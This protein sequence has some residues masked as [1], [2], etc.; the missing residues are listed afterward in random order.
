MNDTE[1]EGLLAQLS[2]LQ[3]G[4]VSCSR[5]LRIAR[6]PELIAPLRRKALAFT[7][8]DI[9][10]SSNVISSVERVKVAV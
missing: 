6:Q 3:Q 4:Q 5:S 10:L 9:S 7:M 2:N 1:R 8:L